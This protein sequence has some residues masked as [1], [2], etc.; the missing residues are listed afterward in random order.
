MNKL[1]V[2]VIS[3]FVLLFMNSCNQTVTMV[4]T[5]GEAADVVDDTQT[6]APDIS[7]TVT[8]PVSAIPGA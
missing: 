1:F 8:V 2:L 4:H 5:Q 6:N 3:I 7:P